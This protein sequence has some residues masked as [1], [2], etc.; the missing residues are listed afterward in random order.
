MLNKKLRVSKEAFNSAFKKSRIISSPIFLFRFH[1][2]DNNQPSKFSFVVSKSVSKK[3]VV[4]NLLKRRGYASVRNNLDKIKKSYICSFSF[5][6][7]SESATF[8]E[9]SGEVA[10]L[11]KKAG[12]LD[13]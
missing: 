1:K 12:I 8:R 11:L 3:A 13:F 7:G 4:R 9:I 6:K 5:K 10:S 2:E